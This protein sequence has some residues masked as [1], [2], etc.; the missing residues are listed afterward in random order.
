MWIEILNCRYNEKVCSE[1]NFF[2]IVNIYNFYKLKIPLRA[3]EH[4]LY[5]DFFFIYLWIY[6]I[7][8]FFGDN[9]EEIDL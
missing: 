4:L 9:F 8:L 6:F 3:E 7:Y 1:N 5:I 2:E